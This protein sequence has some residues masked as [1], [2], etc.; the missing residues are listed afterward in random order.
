MLKLA[1]GNVATFFAEVLLLFTN[2]RC[3]SSVLKNER[4]RGKVFINIEG[5][6]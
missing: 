5:K 1:F 4:H 6:F 3:G 2:F